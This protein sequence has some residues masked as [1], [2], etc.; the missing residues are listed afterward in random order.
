MS[1]VKCFIVGG[2]VR[3]LVLGI[4]PK[5][6][7]FVIT[8]ATVD[9]VRTLQEHGFE[10]VGAD[11]P[12]FLHPVTGAEYALAR[13]ERKVGSGYA[14]FEVFTS[15]ELTIRDDLK[16]RD[17]TINSMAIEITF[18]INNPLAD[19]S[20]PT[21]RHSTLIDPFGGIIDLNDKVLR[22]T[23]DAFVED[24]VRVLRIARFAA[25]YPEF[26]IANETL[27]L[28]NNMADNGE[29]NHLVPERVFKEVEKAASE[30]NFSRFFECLPEKCQ[31]AIF[32][33]N[34]L[35]IMNNPILLET[36]AKDVDRL[37]TVDQKIA[38]AFMFVSGFE[39]TMRPT[40]HQLAVRKTINVP[41]ITMVSGFKREVIDCVAACRRA[42][43]MNQTN[44]AKFNDVLAILKVASPR[45]AVFVEKIVTEMR[46]VDVEGELVKSGKKPNF[47]LVNDIIVD[48]I[49]N[50]VV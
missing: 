16:R 50:K 22:H 49:F 45:A 33:A 46:K 31:F 2:A 19:F 1:N 11:F 28:M 5:D 34:V 9:D 14:G 32:Q 39:E 26:T 8:G 7:D 29:L 47:D 10:Q 42:G 44:D 35:E 37:D 30:K 12:V 40:S 36:N 18:D 13:I 17:L 48:A 23:S 4:T 24:P 20:V 25:R 38:F 21:I 3:D 15:P 6:I 41:H 43:F 27:A